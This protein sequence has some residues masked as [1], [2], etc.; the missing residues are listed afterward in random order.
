MITI[1][2]S[3]RRDFRRNGLELDASVRSR[4]T[5]IQKE[6]GDL[7]IEFQRNLGEENTTLNLDA[8]ELEGMP[9]E[10]LAKLPRS[11]RCD[12]HLHCSFILGFAIIVDYTTGR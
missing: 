5:E 10:F 3:W 8:K 6:M 1:V 9:E 12:C 7:K 4:V 2:F 11:V